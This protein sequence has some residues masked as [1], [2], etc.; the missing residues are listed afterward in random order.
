MFKQAVITDE[1][2]EVARHPAVEAVERGVEIEPEA[3]AVD[4]QEHFSQ[5]QTQ[6]NKLCIV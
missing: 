4:F 6:E 2:Q 1:E 3:Q 5:K